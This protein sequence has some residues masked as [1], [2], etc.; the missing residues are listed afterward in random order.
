M[1]IFSNNYI[2]DSNLKIYEHTISSKVQVILK[3]Y[4]TYLT[5][6]PIRESNNSYINKSG[7]AIHLPNGSQRQRSTLLNHLL[8]SIS[9]GF[10]TLFQIQCI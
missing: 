5:K 9:V 7:K 3:K 1:E 8:I 6:I 10:R 4:R 2:A